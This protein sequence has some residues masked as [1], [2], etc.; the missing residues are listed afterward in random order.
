M[1]HCA[2]LSS[3]TKPFPIY[4]Q[5]TYGVMEEFFKQGDKEKELGIEVSAMCDRDSVV[6]DKAQVSSTKIVKITPLV[7]PTPCWHLHYPKQ[8]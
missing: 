4:K 6:V 1:L 5:W 2:D 8:H 3:P 7:I